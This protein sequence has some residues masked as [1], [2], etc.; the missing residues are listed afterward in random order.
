MSA[1]ANL[2]GLLA[3]IE[4]VTPEGGEWCSVEKADQLAALVLALRPRII[5]ELG[6]FAGG[7][8]I[9]LA[10]AQQHY[11]RPGQ[12][13]TWAID[14]WSAE[15]S[16]AGQAGAN[17]AWWAN[18]N[19]NAVHNKFMRRV[20]QHGLDQLVRVFRA[21]SDDVLPPERCD[22]LHVDANHG[23]QATRDVERFAPCIPTGGILVLDDLEWDGGG[24]R[25]GYDLAISMGFLEL[26]PL[27]TGA[28][29]QRVRT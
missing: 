17:H 27:G 23:E 7:S 26:Y 13:E 2:S 19:H 22:F 1:R 20:E 15:A 6:V 25:R 16:I 18:V 21:K 3:V 9:P 24:V 8:L 5:I 28:V 10:M 11:A 29:L 4:R 12:E 14:A